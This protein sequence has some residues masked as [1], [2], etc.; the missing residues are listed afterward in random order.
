MNEIDDTAKIVWDYMHMH[1]S[2]EEA[3]A[4]FALG[5]SDT[6]VAERAAQL[7]LEGWAPLVVFSGNTGVKGRA[8][9]M[10]GMSEAEKFASIAKE[11]GVPE[12]AMLLEKESTN[13]GQN[14]EFTRALLKE[15][16][17]QVKKLILVQKPYM[18]RRTYATCRKQ[19]PEIDI[20]V[21]SPDISFEQYS[22]PDR[23]KEDVINMMV[24][25][26]QRIKEY[27]ALGYQIPQDIPDNVWEAYEFLVSKGFIRYLI[28]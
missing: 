28:K 17:L 14:I 8:R 3:D 13:T 20:L 7:F 16:G 15:R 5:S 22:I 12:N 26:L 1:H 21:T 24:G 10:W 23:P 25:D 19:W 6:R 27:P 4:V 2:L 11:M 18:E 9:E